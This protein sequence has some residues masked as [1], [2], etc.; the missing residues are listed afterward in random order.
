MNDLL[1]KLSSYNVFNYL[2][3]GVLFAVLATRTTHYN[4][5]QPEIIVGLFVYYFIG[6]VLSRIGSL[7]IEPLL[8]KLKVVTFAPYREF[9]AA[10]K[11]DAKIEVLSEVNNTYRSLCSVFIAELLLKGYERIEAFFPQIRRHGA[12]LVCVLLLVMFLLSYRKQT[13][14]ITKR[15]RANSP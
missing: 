14:Y 9:V 12:L 2:F 8:R 13:G 3:P 1:N 10:C 7:L 5:M 4:F 11:S 15:I 6:L